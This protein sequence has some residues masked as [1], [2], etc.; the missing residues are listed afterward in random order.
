MENLKKIKEK[1]S[2]GGTAIW[3]YTVTS[4]LVQV[5]WFLNIVVV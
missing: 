4:E 2:I 5:L 3:S 1:R